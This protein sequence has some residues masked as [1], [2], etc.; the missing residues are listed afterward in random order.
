MTDKILTQHPQGKRGVN[1]D[2]AKYDA[3]RD[4]IMEA[5]GG[6]ELTHRELLA[7]VEQA[8]EG[9]FDGSIGWYMETVKLDLE[10]RGLIARDDAKPQRYRLL[11]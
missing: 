4:A 3:V 2:R 1:I 5:L 10:A 11:A 8:L 9:S 7:G 6:G